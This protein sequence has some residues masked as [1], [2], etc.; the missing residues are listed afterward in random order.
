MRPVPMPRPPVNPVYSKGKWE[1]IMRNQVIRPESYPNY[2]KGLK[3]QP[4]SAGRHTGHVNSRIV[5]GEIA[6]HGQFPWQVL[7][8][9][10]NSYVCGGSL[11]ASNWILTAG[12][13]ADDFRNFVVVLGA[14]NVNNQVEPGREIVQTTD[15][16]VHEGYDPVEI[17]NDISLLKLP[18]DIQTSQYINMVRLPSYSMASDDLVGRTV[19]VSG[20]GKPSDGASGISPDLRF[21][22]MPVMTNQECAQT[23]GDVITPSKICTDTQGG[24]SSCNGDSGGPLVLTGSDGVMIEV[25]IVSFGAAAGC[26]QGYPAAFTR[27]T[28]FLEWIETNTGIQ[29]DQ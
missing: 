12:H 8:S 26:E 17:N 10:D 19:T 4:A 5:G 18:S 21:V 13:C 14:Q 1:H 7:I 15:K 27:V 24:R 6:T 11:I 23:Y 3:P 29:I 2:K 28:S 9:M 25:G 16:I 22:S 20:W